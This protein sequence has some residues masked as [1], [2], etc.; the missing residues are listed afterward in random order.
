MV[1]VPQTIKD[2]VIKNIISLRSTL[3]KLSTLILIYKWKDVKS[4]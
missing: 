3:D 1:C 4:I 2:I